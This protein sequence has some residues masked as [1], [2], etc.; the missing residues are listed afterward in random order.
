MYPTITPNNNKSRPFVLILNSSQGKY[1]CG[2]ETWIQAT[3]N[4][5][6]HLAG[7]DVHLL[8][9]TE[10]VMWDVVTYL[11]GIDK[12]MITLIIKTPYEYGGCLEYERLIKEF[13]L[14]KESTSPMFIR[15]SGS[16]RRKEMWK[17]RDRMMLEYADII[18]PVSI[19]PGGRLDKMLT[20]A[21]LRAKV[22]YDFKIPWSKSINILQYNLEE[23]SFKHLPAGDWLIHWTR[24]SQGPWPGEEAWKFYKDMF[25]NPSIYVRSAYETLIRI[26]KEKC[27]RGSSWRM[28]GGEK[29]VSFTSL[30]TG[31]A[32]SLMRWRKRFVRY[33]F[34]P[35]GIAV[36]RDV[37]ASIGAQEVNYRNSNDTETDCDSLFVQSY[38]KKADWKKEEEWR[39]RGDLGLDNI[40]KKDFLVLIPDES[41]AR[42]MSKRITK[43]FLIHT[44]F[45]Q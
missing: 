3:N 14:E 13:A 17:E 9:S 4:L 38:G 26:I 10:P 22:C 36:K 12:M 16:K 40:D 42:M 5:V 41:C 37:L 31:N 27:I 1:P 44:L 39:L 21:D 24:A 8:C 35:Y 15:N 32:A 34:E 45:K 6:E 19:R 20:V 23:R 30:S 43:D 7:C 29:A 25:A 33:S 28:S 11:A 2:N 18:Y